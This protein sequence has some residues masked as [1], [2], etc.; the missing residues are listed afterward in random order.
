MGFLHHFIRLRLTALLRHI[1]LF[2]IN[3]VTLPSPNRQLPL[4]NCNQALLSTQL[5]LSTARKSPWLSWKITREDRQTDTHALGCITM[6]SVAAPWLL[7]RQAGG[8]GWPPAPAKSSWAAGL[9]VK[10]EILAAM[11]VPGWGEGTLVR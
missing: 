6:G 9:S 10:E 5:A 7:C 1:V 4:G 8:M 2:C 11:C 3:P